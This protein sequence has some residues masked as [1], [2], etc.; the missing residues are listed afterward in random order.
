MKLSAWIGTAT[1]AIATA[2][3]PA[4][5]MVNLPEIKPGITTASEVESRM[6][7]PGFEF[8]NDD[9]SV[10]WEYSR[11]PAGTTCYMITINSNQIVAFLIS[12]VIGFLFV[13]GF[14]APLHM[15]W[16]S[17]DSV[18]RLCAQQPTHQHG[19]HIPAAISNQVNDDLGARDA[20]DHSIGF[21]SGLSVFFDAQCDQFF[22][23][24]AA[25]W[26]SRQV[27]NGLQ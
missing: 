17:D 22:G 25:F 24:I 27:L 13:S 19:L 16:T 14:D 10:T 12:L 18:A 26:K 7:K 21:E 3:L 23:V 6:G 1:A 11:Q 9:G 4:C 5:D 20:V 8:Q 2:L 15:R